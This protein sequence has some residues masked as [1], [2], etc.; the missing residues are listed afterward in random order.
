MEWVTKNNQQAVEYYNKAKELCGNA[1]KITEHIMNDKE[2]L[3]KRG[4]S[5]NELL[6]LRDLIVS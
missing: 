6:M 1:D 3:L 5:E 4:V 2:V